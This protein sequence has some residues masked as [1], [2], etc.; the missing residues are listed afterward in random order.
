MSRIDDHKEPEVA[1]LQASGEDNPCE[2][3]IQSNLKLEQLLLQK[4]VDAQQ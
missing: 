1:H 2:D 3:I 4:E